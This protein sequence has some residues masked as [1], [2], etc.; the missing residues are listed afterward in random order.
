MMKKDGYTDADF[1]TV[2]KTAEQ[3]SVLP[4]VFYSGHCTGEEPFLCM[5]EIMKDKLC[6]M[7]VGDTFVT[8]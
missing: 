4:T 3:L 1:D 6:P 8:S 2:R 5:K 7:H